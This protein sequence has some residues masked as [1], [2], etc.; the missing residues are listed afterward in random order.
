MSGLL[1]RKRRRS[2][3]G[4]IQILEEAFHLVRTAD[5]KWFLIY[6]AG[7]VPF[8]VALL[9]FAADMS[10]S[11]HADRDAA[12]VAL[13]MTGFYFW[14]RFC[15]AKYCSGLW[16]TISPGQLPKQSGMQGFRRTAAL[17]CLQ[18]FHLPILVVASFLAVPFGWA[19]AMV[20]NFSVLAYTQD[21]SKR[22]LIDLFG[23]SIRL[24]HYD[25]A[26]NHGVL[27]IFA[28]VGFFTWINVI[29]TCV[30]VP[31]FVKA[32]TG[33]ES[34]FTTSP[35]VAMGNSTFIVGTLLLVYLVIS[36]VVKATFVLRC[37]YAESRT[38]GADLLSRLASCRERREKERRRE[39]GG[40]QKAATIAL[41]GILLFSGS[42]L[43]AQEAEEATSPE[44]LRD[45]IGE[46]MRQKKY[47]WKL[48]RL[49]QAEQE[50][51]EKSWLAQRMSEIADSVQAAAEKIQNGIKDWIE[52]SQKNERSGNRENPAPGSI[53]FSTTMTVLLGI[54]VAAV[55]IWLGI[56]LYK[57]F[58]EDDVFESEDSGYSGAVDLESEDI[59]ATQLPEDEWMRMAREQLEKGEQRLAVR[60]LFLA[61][62][63]NLGEAGFLRI[64]RFKSNLDY[65]RELELRL[66]SEEALRSSFD[67]NTRMF[68][69]VWYGLHVLPEDR[70]DIF[71]KNY[72]S[73]A[74]QTRSLRQP[75]ELAE[76]H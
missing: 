31:T 59:V 48:S 9:Y 3:N 5:L 61:I 19:I 32:F 58:K 46:T 37:F 39:K 52:R 57:K 74:K 20:Q 50:A 40:L 47:Q 4:S 65:R 16:D 76:A 36:P 38:T 54:L 34:V 13:W 27:L 11:S 62:L 8:C 30:I 7:V 45:R 35:M 42:P 28:V 25:W 73:I 26:Q 68:E 41:A 63:A 64:A 49:D 70:L 1:R 72:E 2:E 53:G 29:A 75:K 24:S 14:M 51:T 17:F 43:I 23:S 69:R 15:Q 10:R 67:D 44:Q 6:Y 18:S 21:Y 55:V 71:M 66:R 22:P 12:F 60:A 33:I 56:L